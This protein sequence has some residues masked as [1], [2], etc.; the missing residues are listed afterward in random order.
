[1]KILIVT[2]GSFGEREISLISAGNVAQALEEL[3]HSISFFDLANDLNLLNK[4]AKEV[5]LVFPI[6]HGKEGEGGSLQE[7]LE[8]LKIKFV[9]SE[10][11]ACK[12]GWDKFDFKNFCQKYSI[13]TP[14]WFKINKKNFG[15][16]IFR[17]PFVV[18]PSDSGSSLDVYLVKSK[19]DLKNI[20]FKKLFRKY[21]NLMIEEYIN[22]VEVTVGILGKK[23]LPVIEIKLSKGELFDFKNKYNGKTEEILNAPSLNESQRE[24]VKEIAFLIYSLLGCRHYLRVDFILNKNG[25]YAL[26]VNTIPGLTKESLFPKAAKA[27]GLSFKQMINELI[28]LAIK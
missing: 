27:D 17:I 18:K 11:K 25:I 2:G 20:D 16:F 22:G 4:R 9:G 12:I 7:S 8:K 28:N 15:K 23:I 14:R 1:M 5:D 19:T 24:K 26:E 13:K 6:I 3:G 10:S 21:K